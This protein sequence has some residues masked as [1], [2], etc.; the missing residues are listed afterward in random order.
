MSDAFSASV[1]SASVPATRAATE[2]V[3]SNSA[4]DGAQKA[5]AAALAAQVVVS[6]QT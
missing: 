1:R 5:T 4:C 6:G 3:V 2:S